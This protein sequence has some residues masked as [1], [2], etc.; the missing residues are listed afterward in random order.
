MDE[1]E[2]PYGNPV[3]IFLAKKLDGE[4]FDVVRYDG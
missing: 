1:Y 3:I 4:R 2:I